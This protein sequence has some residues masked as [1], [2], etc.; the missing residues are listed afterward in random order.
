MLTTATNYRYVQVTD[1]GNKAAI[2]LCEAGGTMK[3]SVNFPQVSPVQSAEAQMNF[4]QVCLVQ[5]EVLSRVP[6]KGC[7]D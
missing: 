5:I 7:L 1:N 4:P 6:G 2:T 3:P